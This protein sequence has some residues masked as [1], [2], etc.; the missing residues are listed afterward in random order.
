MRGV[1]LS[2]YEKDR[3][4]NIARNKNEL[5]RLGLKRKIVNTTSKTKTKN[6]SKKVVR[7]VSRKPTVSRRVSKRLR[8][9]DSD[10]RRLPPAPKPKAKKMNHSGD[11]VV[12]EWAEKLLEDKEKSSTKGCHWCWDRT[13]T[14]QHLELSKDK[15]RVATIGC[16]GYG[17]SLATRKKTVQGDG[18]S[19]NF[20]IKIVKV[21]V[22]GFA[23]GVAS[24]KFQRPFKSIGKHPFSWVY[25]SNGSFHHNKIE[26]VDWGEP[27]GVGDEVQVSVSEN[28]VV[29]F[30]NGEEQ[31]CS[32]ISGK[33]FLPAIQIVLLFP[34]I[35]IFR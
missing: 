20:G 22:G 1:Q 15:L 33:E 16:A 26:Q 2:Q 28:K 35:I 4:K 18:Q 5:E 6:V 13:K 8:G 12:P 32:H 25:H 29:F 21:G 14:H 19:W 34:Y 3:L 31:G 10:G 24:A 30:L 9:L 7:N 27:F 11:V 23:V 17:A